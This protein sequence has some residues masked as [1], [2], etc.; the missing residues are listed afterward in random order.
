MLLSI[1]KSIY[2]FQELQFDLLELALV[3]TEIPL[4]EFVDIFTTEFLAVV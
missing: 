1:V 4:L 2:H 3:N